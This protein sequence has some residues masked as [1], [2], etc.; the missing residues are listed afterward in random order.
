[1]FK[2]TK[3]VNKNIGSL[4]IIAI[5]L[6]VAL[7]LRL[8]FGSNLMF[9]IYHSE[10]CFFPSRAMYA[11]MYI[12]RIIICAYLSVQ[13]INN[14]VYGISAV[15][16]ISLFALYLEY[17]LIFFKE[18]ILTV[19]ILLL[20]TLIINVRCIKNRCQKYEKNIFAVIMLYLYCIM[21]II[22]IISLISVII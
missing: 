10:L 9:Y 7:L 3:C 21:Q 19:I 18:S 8:R 5:S 12:T 2:K 22:I 17:W 4:L 1:M 6:L 13:F 16:I 20:F 15:N 11:F 14:R